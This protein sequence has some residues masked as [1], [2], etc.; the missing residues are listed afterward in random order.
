MG[1]CAA[2][3]KGYAQA[4]I[5]TGGIS[6]DE[7]FTGELKKYI[8]SFAPVVVMA[9]EFEMEALAAGALRVLTGEEEAK[10]YTGIPSW[11]GFDFQ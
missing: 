11:N 9:G 6:H 4:I 10:E 5:L 3:L 1:S 7:Y 2:V 8:S